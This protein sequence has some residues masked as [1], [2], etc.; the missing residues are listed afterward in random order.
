MRKM[1]LFLI[2]LCGVSV[3]AQDTTIDLPLFGADGKELFTV[4]NPPDTGIIVNKE[5][6]DGAITVIAEAGAPDSKTFGKIMSRDDFFDDAL[7]QAA[8]QGLIPVDFLV[9]IRYEKQDFPRL[10][11]YTSFSEGKLY[12]PFLRLKEGEHE[13]S[14]G[15][16]RNLNLLKGFQFRPAAGL[17][18]TIT[19]ARLILEVNN[20]AKKIPVELGEVWKTQELLPGQDSQLIA[21]HRRPGLAID[22]G[23]EKNFSAHLNWESDHLRLRAQAHF[24]ESP[25]AQITTPDRDVWQD[26]SLEVFLSPQMDNESFL[27]FVINA[28]GCVMDYRREYCEVACAIRNKYEFNLEHTQ[29]ISYQSP[30]L[31][32]NIAFPWKA[33]PFEPEKE[34]LMAFQLVQNWYR[35]ELNSVCWAPTIRNIHPW[36]F[37]LLYFNQRS[38]GADELKFK[39]IFLEEPGDTLY[40]EVEYSPELSGSTVE[41]LLVAP[42][43]STRREKLSLTPELQVPGVKNQNGLYT[44]TLVVH[45]GDNIKPFAL[46]FTHRR[47]IRQPFYQKQLF[48]TPKECTW[49]E[50][51]FP[52][53]KHHRLLLPK[54][55]SERTCLTA[56][57]F[58]EKLLGFTGRRYET[59]TTGSGIRLAIDPSGLKAEGYRLSVK[60]DSV[61]ITGADE[62]GLFY[63][64][65]SFIQ[66]LK[67]D[68]RCSADAPAPCCEVRDW[69]DLPTRLAPLWHPNNIKP[70]AGMPLKESAPVD[71]LLN[72]LD[73]FM[74]GNKMNSLHLQG[75][76][77]LLPLDDIHPNLN[78]SPEKRYYTEKDL[79]RLGQ[80]CRDHFIKLTIAV[81]A[82]GH[83]T[84]ILPM[85]SDFREK[86]WQNTGNVAH[87]DYEKYYFAV[88]DKFIRATQCEYFSPL[89]DEWWHNRMAGELPTDEDHAAKFLNFHLHL[90]EFLR[91]RGVK[92]AM[93]EDM[94]NP[95]HNGARFN[96][97]LNTDKLPKDITIM[98]WANVGN[99]VKYFADKGFPVW[100]AVTGW[101]E[102]PYK[103]GVSGFGASLY[104]FGREYAF[105]VNHSFVYHS[106]WFHGANYAW[107]F[108]S[109]GHNWSISD[110][111]N[112][113]L[114]TVQESLAAQQP[115]PAASHCIEPI[116]LVGFNCAMPEV[117][118]GRRSIMGV[119]TEISKAELNCVRVLPETVTLVPANGK[120]ASLIFL[121]TAFPGENYRRNQPPRPYWRQW[122]IAY[123]IAAYT[124]IYDDWSEVEIP[125]RLSHQ[126][127]FYHYQPQAGSTVFGRY[128]DI[129][130][131]AEF[132]PQILYQYEWVNP[133]PEKTIKLIKFANPH[134]FDFDTRIFAVSGRLPL[135]E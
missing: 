18:F 127:Y 53:A 6:G 34:R 81:A 82:G 59:E 50:G 38:F 83:D 51:S 130:Y 126:I 104:Q 94:L 99:A 23:T 44:L 2:L 52:A 65:V 3:F 131:N 128:M 39:Q 90:Y 26:D 107:N 37:G 43:K 9:R 16:E 41:F 123:P 74:V 102:F 97:H 120:Y 89:S 110:S 129:S 132:Q 91:A 8:A 135:K 55:A 21:F 93:Y 71:F 66:L 36:T 5:S 12:P 118:G 19:G 134:K 125:I 1:A 68:M 70:H 40:V 69:P 87:P 115:N 73:S 56:R 31:N 60:P 92:M 114:L 13:Y 75:L 28:K 112:S 133:Y 122:H 48:P 10:I 88:A 15:G 98:V 119:S 121:H 117:Q 49:G 27:Q 105:R 25:R 45:K 33:I 85:G 11:A 46:N 77:T 116:P 7:Q 20:E 58:A 64:C 17:R 54:N 84:M 109:S 111:L 106:H 67:M 79:R 24:P 108:H 61:L 78:W 86:G 14:F 95:M 124:A 29:D 35:S 57:L 76:E 103:E 32:W 4:Y 100:G 62:A 113:G 72:F 30:T 63:G 101:K 96:N 42:D 80:F 47:P 22:D